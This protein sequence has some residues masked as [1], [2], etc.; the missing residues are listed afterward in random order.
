M[1][2]LFASVLLIFRA[3]ILSLVLTLITILTEPLPAIIILPMVV[4]PPGKKC[5]TPNE[6]ISFKR[7]KYSFAER[8]GYEIIFSI[9]DEKMS[10]SL[11]LVLLLL[12]NGGDNISLL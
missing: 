8:F 5:V 10:I 6:E 12:Y 11:L 7:L 9:S 3:Q 2:Y 1:L 4:L